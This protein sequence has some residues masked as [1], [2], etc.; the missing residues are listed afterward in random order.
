MGSKGS[1]F[2][3][4][5]VGSVSINTVVMNRNREILEEHYTRIHGQ[6]LVKAYGVLQEILSRIS[7]SQLGSVSL[8]GSGGKLIAELLGAVFRNEI[9]AQSRAVEHFYPQV[10]TVVEMGG[11]DSKLISLELDE[12]SRKIK[13]SD[14]TMNSVCAAGTG[15][16]LDQQAHRLG[17]SVEEFGQLALKSKNPPRIAGR[18]SVFAKRT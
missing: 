14:F 6:P 8:T 3:G 9:I 4:M 7:P 11:E 16:F 18:C 2:L 17:L 13:I 12:K 15:S 10:K 1:Y 5:D